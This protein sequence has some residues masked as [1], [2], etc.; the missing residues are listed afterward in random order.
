MTRLT[1]TIK[2][3]QEQLRT[4]LSL[5]EHDFRGLK[6]NGEDNYTLVMLYEKG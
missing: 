5:N 6:C 4:E 2:G 1:N 3:T